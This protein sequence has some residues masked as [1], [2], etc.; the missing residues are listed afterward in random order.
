[1][2]QALVFA[3]GDFND[4]PA[5]RRVLSPQAYVIAADGGAMHPLMLGLRVD[6][7]IGD[8]DSIEPLAL[9]RLEQ[10]GCDVRR[11]PP[12]KNETDLEL[13][14]MAAAQK[15]AREIHIIGAVGNRLDQTLANVYLLNLHCLEGRNVQIVAGKQT[16]W[17]V[18][19]G[20]HTLF[21]DAG[22]TLSLIPLGGDVSGL[23]TYGLKYPLRRERLLFGPARGVS[24]VIT[25]P[26]ARLSVGQGRVLILHTIGR[27]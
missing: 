25:Q 26:P 17:Q 8:M 16:I 5:L 4:G 20:E 6:M 27:A 14:L 15:N 9:Q 13:A 18:G 7:V 21:G 1:M 2:R 11:F 10:E 22:D 3:N 23:T 12:D 19:T 24:N